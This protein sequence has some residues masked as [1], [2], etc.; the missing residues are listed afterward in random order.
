[1]LFNTGASTKDV[2]GTPPEATAVEEAIG[3]YIIPGDQ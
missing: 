2:D 3:Q 1:M